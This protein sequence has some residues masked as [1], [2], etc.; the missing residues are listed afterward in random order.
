MATRTFGQPIARREDERLL[1]GRGTYIDDVAC[2]GAL[3]ASFLR[4]PIAHGRITTLDLEAA[5]ALPGVVAVYGAADL[6][7]FNRPLPLL[8]PDPSI[9]DPWTQPP[10]ATDEV[11]YGGQ[12]VAM[13][14]AE[15]RYIAEDAVD[16]IWLEVDRLPAVV[17]PADALAQP[18]AHSGRSSNLASTICQQV[19]DPDR[20]FAEADVILHRRYV[21]DRSA[22]MPMETRGLLARFDPQTGDLVVWDST[23]APIPIRAGLIAALGLPEERV[24]VIAPDT[25]GGFGVKAFFFYPEEMLVPWA[26][27]QLGRPV[28]WIEDRMEHFV[29]SNHERKQIH[30]VELAATRDGVVLGLRDSFVHDTGA[31]I[32]YGN[33]LAVVTSAHL[34]GPYRIPNMRVEATTVYTNTVPVSP[35]RGAGRPHACFVVERALDDLAR[36]LDI[37]PVEVR[38]R[39]FVAPDEFPYVRDGMIFLDGVSATLDSGDYQRQMDLL[40]ELVDRH[41]FVDERA[42]ARAEG[43]CVGIGIACYVE[44]TGVPPYEGAHVMVQPHTGKVRVATG[45]TSQ[46]QG[47]ATTLAQIAADELGVPIEDVVVVA[48]D[49]GIFPWGVATYASRAAVIVGNAVARAAAEVREKAIRLAANMLEAAPEDLEVVD[50]RV[51]VRGA[52]ARGVTLR[53]VAL[54]ANPARYSFD[55]E[56]AAVATFAPPRPLGDD[57]LPPGDGPGLEANGFFSPS[58]ST[59]ASGVHAALMEVNPETGQ[60]RYLRFAAVHDCGTVVN[61]MVVEGQVC[62]G[63]AQ[64]VGG[65]LYEQLV[66]DED[67][68]LRNGSF[69]DFLIPYATEVPPIVV[70]HL[71]SPTP[72]N[73]LGI[74]GAGEAGVIPGAAVAAAAIEDAL[75]EY[76]V[77]LRAMPISPAALSAAIDERAA[78]WLTG[79]GVPDGPRDDEVKHGR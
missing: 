27:V 2:E 42:A 61:P 46:G 1:R 3:H 67:G 33:T 58:R 35:Y 6:G 37:D 13:V 10:L 15:S 59:W 69:M 55:P 19:G 48:G 41:G 20:A 70:D 76:G 72:L 28:K 52:P 45:A 54:A 75:R 39:N 63:I 71:E 51:S 43:R 56:L 73:P 40:L 57:P 23:Q 12:T 78:S 49:T 25:G 64:G 5:R 53:Q 24:R 17:D 14:V 29:G 32:A 11:V 18:P 8:F 16:R 65:A 7:A 74:K 66:Y 50:G 22:A 44:A 60:A 36:E 21:L 62:G 68:Q 31:S 38:R 30:D 26:S 34:G 79:A 47:H 4:S 77:E 9:V